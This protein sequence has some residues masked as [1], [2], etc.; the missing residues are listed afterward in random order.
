MVSAD[1][2]GLHDL[3]RSE[4][5]VDSGDCGFEL[6]RGGRGGGV[7]W[8]W[9]FS[10]CSVQGTSPFGL[11]CFSELMA[12]KLFGKVV[13]LGWFLPGAGDE[14]DFPSPKP[15]EGCNGGIDVGGVGLSGS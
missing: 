12:W 13:M 2:R 1:D 8:F 5:R 9:M 7:F 14:L 10:R 4:V 3:V 6:G 11:C 15:L